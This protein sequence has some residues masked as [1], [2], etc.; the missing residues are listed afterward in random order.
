LI[1]LS[2]RL[3]RRY[4]DAAASVQVELA[5][6]RTGVVH[7]TVPLPPGAEPLTSQS[8][9]MKSAVTVA[10]LVSG[11]TQTGDALPAHGPAVHDR[12]RFPAVELAV[13]TSDV[14]SRKTAL[15]EG[16]ADPQEIAD[17]LET[18]VP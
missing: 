1:P 10:S 17:G 13:R 2:V 16:H 15:W 11:T 14:P 12:N 18:T 5:A 4:R 6:F 3:V 8:P 9:A 7:E